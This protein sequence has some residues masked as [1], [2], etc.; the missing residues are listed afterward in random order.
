MSRKFSALSLML[1]TVG[2]TLSPQPLTIA[3]PPEKASGKMVL[4]EVAEGLRRYRKE[5]NLAKRVDW[6]EKFAPTRDPRVAIALNEAI[7][8]ASGQLPESMWFRVA[9][10]LDDYYLRNTKFHSEKHI[11]L[12]GWWEANE[13]DL[14]RRAK[15]LPR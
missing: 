12:A 15:L 11:N 14:R 6:L 8:G 5:S 4:D 7:T 1:V 13:A 2:L 10:L 9:Y 3:G